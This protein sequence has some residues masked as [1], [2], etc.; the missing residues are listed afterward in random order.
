MRTEFHFKFAA[1]D[2]RCNSEIFLSQ[3]TNLWWIIISNIWNGILN[4]SQQNLKW[5]SVFIQLIWRENVS[6]Y[7]TPPLHH[8]CLKSC[9][10]MTCLRSR[11]K[12]PTFGTFYLEVRFPVLSTQE[13]KQ[14]M[15][16]HGLRQRWWSGGVF[17]VVCYT[18]IHFCKN[19]ISS[20]PI[21]SEPTNSW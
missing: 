14:V 5:K 15:T 18:G 6:H 1:M 12:S 20:W 8:L 7:K 13:R 9:Q 11:V 4:P 17:S 19:T 2:L 16:W 10:V 3:N 21:R